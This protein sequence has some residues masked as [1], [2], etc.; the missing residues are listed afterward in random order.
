MEVEKV[1]IEANV[2]RKDRKI[3]KN[4]QSA[5]IILQKFLSS[6]QLDTEEQEKV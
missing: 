6:I 5:I 1:L 4:K 2:K 3:I